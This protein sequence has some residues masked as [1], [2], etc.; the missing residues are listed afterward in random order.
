[1]RICGIDP[2]TRATGYGVIDVCSGPESLVY[3]THGTLRPRSEDMALRLK[4]IFQGLT[5]VFRRFGPGEVAVET[6]FHALNSQTALKL[7]Q[8]R[9]AILLAASLM[10]IPVFEYTPTE[11][12]KATCGYGHAGKDQIH[13]M[14]CTILH[15]SK[16]A[17]R[18]MDASDALAIGVC[19]SSSRRMRR[20]T[21]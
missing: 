8:A 20:L 19:H 11:V 2:G 1:M 17:V 6:S 18:S 15:L 10:E 21:P 3:V 7:G 4:E 12:K 5:E 16:D 9:G 14:V 13:A